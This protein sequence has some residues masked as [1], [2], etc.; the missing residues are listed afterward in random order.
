MRHRKSS[1]RKLRQSENARRGSRYKAAERSYLSVRYK[2]TVK[3]AVTLHRKG[4]L[5]PPERC[6]V[7][8]SVDI[9]FTTYEYWPDTAQDATGRH[10]ATHALYGCHDCGARVGA[11]RGTIHPLGYMA[12]G[13]TRRARARYKTSFIELT[14]THFGN[15]KD[16]AY[17]WLAT[18]MNLPPSKAHWG[19]FNPEQCRKAHEHCIAMLFS[20]ND[21]AI[22]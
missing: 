15:S 6:D 20:I 19:M 13:E 1:R 14:K 3:E 7:C 5:Q 22:F 2:S 21:E 17:H 9:E 16:K 12:D 18:V 10:Y 4:I 11:H 8:K